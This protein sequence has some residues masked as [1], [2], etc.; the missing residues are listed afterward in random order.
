MRFTL[1]RFLLLVLLSNLLGTAPAFATLSFTLRTGNSTTG[2]QSMPIDSNQ[3][4][5]QGPRA[6]YVGGVITNTGATTDTNIVATI[7]GLGNGFALA[8]GQPATQ[9]IGTLAPGQ[10]TGAYWFVGY[11]CVDGASTSPLVT[12]SSSA[13]T[14]T[15]TLVLTARSAISA[16]AGGNVTGSLLGPGAVVGQTIYFDASYS[17]G[18][19]DVGDEFFVQPSGGQN[20]NA[21]CF[22]LVGT[23][24]R[25]SNISALTVGTQNQLYFLQNAKQTGNGYTA[26]IRYYFEYQCAGA[27][28]TARP[29]ALQTSGNTNIKYTG[30]FDGSGSVSISF[31]GAT[32]PFTISKTADIASA[33]GGTSTTIKYAVTVSNPSAHASRISQFVD[34]LPAG[35]VYVGLDPASGV[36]AANSSS[37]PSA[38]AT[39]TLTFTG[40][41]DQSYLI[42]AGG[43]VSLIYSV[44]MPAA[45]GT[46]TNNAQAYF[47]GATTPVASMTFTVTAPPPLTIIKTSQPYYDPY[48]GFT[49]PK[50][51]PGSY[52]AYTI[53]I[54]NPNPFTVDNNSVVIT[55]PTPAN[56][57]LFVSNVPNG[58]GPVLFQNGS[59]ASG[60]TYTFSGLAST[61]DDVD[62]SNDGGTS[63]TYVPAPNAA[64]VDPAVTHIR[65]RPKGTMAA[66]SSFNVQFGYLLL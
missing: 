21:A 48:F 18:G 55:D 35:A 61:T 1:P 59:P 20:F 62:F 27:S 10:S 7:S 14:A 23:E 19:S 36:T 40:R 2:A 8:G 65:I 45:Q 6:M 28:T 39:G 30:N 58:T 24:I 63:W 52:V 46:Y 60:L 31:P 29:Y 32:N 50:S 53:S 25:T 43:S 9:T 51:I 44:T 57:Q 33:P 66:N 17:F 54:A 16:N 3:C 11:G 42:A 13:P 34:T 4:A 38:G 64:G 41:Q 49:N 56:L 47:G 22:R 5:S 15:R 26:T 37:V 12:I